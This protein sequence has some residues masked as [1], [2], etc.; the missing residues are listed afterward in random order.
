MGNFGTVGRPDHKTRN[1]HSSPDFWNSNIQNSI[2]IFIH[3]FKYFQSSSLLYSILKKNSKLQKCHSR[4]KIGTIFIIVFLEPLIIHGFEILEPSG[5]GV[6][7]AILYLD[8]TVAVP[9]ISLAQ[10]TYPSRIVFVDG[11]FKREGMDLIIQ[12]MVNNRAQ[13]Y[14]RN[15]EYFQITGH[16][17]AT[18]ED[19]S[20]GATLQTR[21]VNNLA[22]ICNDKTNFPKLTTLNFNNNA[23]NDYNNGFGVALQGACSS[24]VTGVTIQAS[25]V[26]VT[27]PPMCNPNDPS[28]Y[29]YYDMTNPAEIAQ[30]RYTWNWEYM[31][32]PRYTSVGPFPNDDTPECE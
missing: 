23:Y 20:N 31:M 7:D 4:L 9:L 22:I 24:S 17:V 10:Y 14:F 8:F 5:F 6:P 19:G 28:N 11:T 13:G 26:S 12:W 3:Y 27:I 2:I 32:N 1:N 16:K 25:D 30:C 15:L 18:Y 29:W 21:I